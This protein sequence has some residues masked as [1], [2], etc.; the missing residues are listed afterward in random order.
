MRWAVD[1]AGRDI[2]FTDPITQSID[3]SVFSSSKTVTIISLKT[4]VYPRRFQRCTGYL[5]LGC[6]ASHQDPAAVCITTFECFDFALS[7]L[8]LRWECNLEIS[9]PCFVVP[10]NIV[11]FACRDTL[12]SDPACRLC[13]NKTGE[14]EGVFLC[15]FFMKDPIFALNFSI[16]IF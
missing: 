15:P 14:D 13:I 10:S 9:M 16:Q 5:L 8:C 12:V 7:C 4:M 3:L 1:L 11:L 6:E 2:C